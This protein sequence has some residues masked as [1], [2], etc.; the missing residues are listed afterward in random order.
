VACPSCETPPPPDITNCRCLA[1]R[2]WDTNWT[3]LKGNQLSALKT[4]DRV[5]FTVSAAFNK[6]NV[7]KAKFKINGQETAEITTLKPGE[8]AMYYYEYTIPEGVTNFSIGAKI[9]HTTLG[10]SE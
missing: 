8:T 3:E 9:H 1:I 5:R 6:G 4:G 10:W 7:D 2:A